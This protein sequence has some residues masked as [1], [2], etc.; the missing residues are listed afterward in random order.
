[1]KLT[2]VNADSLTSFE[3]VDSRGVRYTVL[4]DR[5]VEFFKLV[6]EHV[7]QTNPDLNVY[8]TYPYTMLQE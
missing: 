2:E 3:F 8:V 6:K 7:R 5:A 1:M 4:A